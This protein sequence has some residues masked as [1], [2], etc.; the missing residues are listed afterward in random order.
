MTTPKAQERQEGQITSEP[1]RPSD[2]IEPFDNKEFS[3]HVEDAEDQKKGVRDIEYDDQEGGPE[4]RKGVKRL[5]RRNPSYNFIREVA[6]ADE[7]PLDQVQVKRASL[8]PRF[9]TTQLTH[10]SSRNVYGG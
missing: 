10:S 7:E 8:V 3:H 6:I 5:L 9:C 4:S 2:D 1:I